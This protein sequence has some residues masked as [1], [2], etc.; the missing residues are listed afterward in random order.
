[1]AQSRHRRRRRDNGRRGDVRL[2]MT[3][4]ALVARAVAADGALR[5]PDLPRGSY[6][7]SWRRET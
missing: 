7:S 6:A 2:G 3:D 5:P 4:A 1:M